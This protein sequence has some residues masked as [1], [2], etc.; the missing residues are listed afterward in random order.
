M[1]DTVAVPAVVP[2]EGHRFCGWMLDGK[3]IEDGAIQMPASDISIVGR[4]E[5]IPYRVSYAYTGTVPAKAPAL[6]EETTYTMGDTVHP[7]AAPSLKGYTF[8][9]WGE[10]FTMP[11]HDMILKG[12]W[13][14]V[15]Y[16]ITYMLDGG[17]APMGNP[18]SY[19]VETSAITFAAP[20]KTG[21]TFQGWFTDSGFTTPITILPFGSTGD[22]TLYAKWQKESSS[23]GGS[24]GGG[25]GGFVPQ[26]PQPVDPPSDPLNKADHIAYIYG[27]PDGTVQPQANISRAEVAV[28]F[29]RLLTEEARRENATT[30]HS[31]VDVV[32]GE[33]YTEAVATLAAMGILKG[34]GDNRF[35]PTATIARAEFAAI[36]AR[37]DSEVYD[38]PDLFPD[39]EGHWANAEINRAA[40]KGWV[41]GDGNGMFRPDAPITRAEA[42]TLINRVL[43]RTPDVDAL[44]PEMKTFPDNADPTAW[45]YTAIQEA[46]NGHSY[47]KDKTGKETWVEVK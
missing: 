32:D 1:G 2:V 8:S 44:L 34:R 7:A 17:T 13:S 29:F 5:K 26:P 42:V 19:T 15:E 4:W 14:A 38:G 12:S 45:Y 46:A 9:G 11:A 6:P 33:W 37:F 43:E 47:T 40:K 41:K 31:F 3:A 16:A 28:I 20:T 23:S 27:M 39:I 36:A 35:D 10:A 24:G 25:G 18:S 21:H 30:E 22:I